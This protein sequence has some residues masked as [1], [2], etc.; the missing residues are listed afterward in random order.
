MT[1]KT[2]AAPSLAIGCLGLI[3]TTVFAVSNTPDSPARADAAPMPAPVMATLDKA[4]EAV[5]PVAIDATPVPAPV[6]PAAK[7]GP[8]PDQLAACQAAL[9]KTVAAAPLTFP[10]EQAYLLRKAKK[11]LARLADM[12][13]GNCSGAR[14]EIS[15]YTDGTGLK[16][17][18]LALSQ[19]RADAVKNYLV[20]L[21]LSAGDLTAIGFGSDRPLASDRTAAG[22]AKNRRIEFRVVSGD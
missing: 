15:G 1:R 9:D 20:D 17:K 16:D 6:V 18:N 21:G 22:R 5:A 7:P 12:V 3:A 10:E 11:T 2:S 13:R 19:D 8:S 4:P 14:M